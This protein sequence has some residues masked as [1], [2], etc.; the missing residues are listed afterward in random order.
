MKLSTSQQSALVQIQQP[1]AEPWWKRPLTVGLVITIIMGTFGFIDKVRVEPI[2][3]QLNLSK[4]RENDLKE[5]NKTLVD[6]IS[7]LRAE[8]DALNQNHQS[9]ISL[10][11]S[12]LFN[13]Y[14][15]SQ[16]LDSDTN[17]MSVGLVLSEQTRNRI[18]N[19]APER[20]EAVVIFSS[21]QE[22]VDLR[23][24]D[25]RGNSA[26]R[27]LTREEGRQLNPERTDERFFE[28]LISNFQ[29]IDPLSISKVV[30]EAN[31]ELA[32]VEQFIVKQVNLK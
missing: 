4:D 32:G 26:Y 30:F 29:Q 17:Q 31:N 14:E 11:D 9:G 15:V 23:I 20:I 8:I 22:W 13:G 27:R 5:Q 16:H 6:K 24:V 21:N 7:E 19:A 2:Q 3:A 1:I 28:L 25:A 10:E 18:A 12:V